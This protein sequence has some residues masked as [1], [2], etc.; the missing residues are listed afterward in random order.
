MQILDFCQLKRMEYNF[1]LIALLSKIEEMIFSQ[2][3]KSVL[4]AFQRIANMLKKAYRTRF[5][6]I[7]QYY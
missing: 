5:S 1:S 6:A 2:R 3:T 7:E 4:K